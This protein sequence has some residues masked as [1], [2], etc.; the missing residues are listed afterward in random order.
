MARRT[1]SGPMNLEL[2]NRKSANLQVK[3]ISDKQTLGKIAGQH[4]GNSIR[5]AIKEKGTARVIAATGA[6]Q[7]EFLHAL[8]AVP[9]I[10]WGCVEL[11]HLDEYVGLPITHPA[12]F[13]KYLLERLIHGTGITRHHLLDGE[14]DPQEVAKR[15]GAE[16]AMKPVDVAFVGI[17]ENGHLAFNDPPADFQTELP[18]LVVELDDACRRQQVGEG[19]FD[20]AEDVPAKAIS[21]SI[22]QIL[23]SLEIIAVVPDAR[24]AKA[25]KACLEGEISPLA[26]ASILRSHPNATI[27]LDKHSAALLST[28]PE[29]AR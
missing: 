18:Y 24:K 11:F 26:P 10:D 2:R 9:Q 4:A 15:I 6:S 19:W 17:G 1:K 28:A 23:R 12:S 16:L 13:R 22:R 20:K 7:F 25:V 8:T 5:S 21:M 27:Y 29:T 14:G 3:I